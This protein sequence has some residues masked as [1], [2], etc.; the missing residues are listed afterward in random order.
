MRRLNRRGNVRP[1]RRTL[2]AAVSTPI[3]SEEPSDQEPS[4]FDGEG[5]PAPT[6]LLSSEASEGLGGV[7]SK[8]GVRLHNNAENVSEDAYL[9]L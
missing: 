2:G 9:L 8:K 5:H 6:N 1:L 4:D 7:N 3:P